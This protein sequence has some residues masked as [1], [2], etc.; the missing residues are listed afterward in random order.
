MNRPQGV[1]VP[2]SQKR[3]ERKGEPNKVYAAVPATMVAVQYADG[4][5]N[6]IKEFWYKVG[7]QYYI[8][9][10]A[11]QFASQLRSVKEGHAAQVNNLLA[12]YHSDPNDI[13]EQDP[14]NVVTNAVASDNGVDV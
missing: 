12:A 1:V 8:P 4:S 5:G 9:P 7:D 11:E 10:Q 6:L 14:V 2:Q 3:S 13:P